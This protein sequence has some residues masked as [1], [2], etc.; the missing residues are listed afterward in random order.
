M[1]AGQLFDCGRALHWLVP[2]V[3]ADLCV[4]VHGLCWGLCGWLVAMSLLALGMYPYPNRLCYARV[5]G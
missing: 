4:F 1:M 2:R 3:C 5:S